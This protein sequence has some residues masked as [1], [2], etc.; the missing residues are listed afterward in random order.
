MIRVKRVYELHEADDGLRFLVDRLW[1]RGMKKENLQMEG[2][3]KDLAPSAD[4]RHWFGH[5]PAKWQEFCRRY[6]A[7]L[8]ANSAAWSDLL[9]MARKQD[10]TLLFSAHDPERNNAVAL[11]SFL[12][13]RL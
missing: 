8:N 2:W 6:D 7:E 1:P 10:I 4:L 11:R 5:D 12:E 3:L 13:K 9:N